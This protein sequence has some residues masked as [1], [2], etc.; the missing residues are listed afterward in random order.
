MVPRQTAPVTPAPLRS[1]SVLHPTASVPTISY[2]ADWHYHH[3]NYLSSAMANFAQQYWQRAS[4]SIGYGN[5]EKRWGAP[6]ISLLQRS[7]LLDDDVPKDNKA[8]KILDQACGMG[9]VTAVFF[10][11]KE[12]SESDLV[13]VVCGDISPAMLN[14]AKARIE[15]M[16]WKGVT[17]QI[18]DAQVRNI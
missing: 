16:G 11:F 5:F 4:P 7:G 9:F 18:V 13:Q 17:A 1:T 12:P 15:K 6:T 8:L 3:A 14:G 10:D 2:K